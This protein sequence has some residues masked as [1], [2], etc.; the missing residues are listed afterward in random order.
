L[1]EQH[2]LKNDSAVAST[3]ATEAALTFKYVD[4]LELED[5]N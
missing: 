1:D 4:K 3:S 2:Q 5:C